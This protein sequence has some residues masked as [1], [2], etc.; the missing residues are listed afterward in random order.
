MATDITHYEDLGRP[1]PNDW[2]QAEGESL[3]RLSDQRHGYVWP[4]R[5]WELAG[6][7]DY[8]QRR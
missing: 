7:A 8:I 4:V 5:Q 6:L 2:D 1:T 3:V